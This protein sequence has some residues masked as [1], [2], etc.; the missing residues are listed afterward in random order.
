MSEDILLVDDDKLL[1]RMMTKLLE[2]EGHNVFAVENGFDAIKKLEE[3]FFDLL[4]LDIRMPGLNGLDV[5]TK[6]REIQKDRDFGSH[7]IVVTGYAS[8]DVP[9]KA[10]RLGAADY[11]MKPFETAEFL[12]S[13]N[14]NLKLI[15]L[16]KEKKA[17]IETL[18][19]KN[20]EL[21]TKN[22][23]LTETQEQLVKAEKWRL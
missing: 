11:I 8:E 13:I 22:K 21:E 23:E 5:L 2:K 12:H 7:V 4:I 14:K 18:K 20:S 17:L 9:V 15:R 1:L 6:I 10:I 3:R 19:E 16:E